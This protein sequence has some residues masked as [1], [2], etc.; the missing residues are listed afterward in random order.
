[1]SSKTE[2]AN[3]AISHLGIGKEIANVETEQSQEAKACRRYFDMAKKITLG[4]VDWT[5]A[6]KFATL[7]LFQYHYFLKK[8]N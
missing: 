8:L 3:L 6:T 4:D 2:I 5:F 1:M 7:N